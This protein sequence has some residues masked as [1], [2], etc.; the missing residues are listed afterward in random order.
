MH[1]AEL[2][3]AAAR[4]VN[5]LTGDA[6]TWLFVTL[7]QPLLWHLHLMD[8]DDLAYDNLLWVVAGALQVGLVYLVLRPLEWLAPLERWDNRR[9]IGPDVIYTL[10]N[11]LGLVPL[12]FFLTLQPLFDLVL[13]WMHLHGWDNLNL[14]A[15]WPTMQLHPLLGFVIYLVVLDFAGYWYHRLQHQIGWWWELHAVHHS[16]R[17]LS[18][19]ADDRNHFVDDALQ[20]AFFAALALFIGVPPGQFIGLALLGGALQSLQHANVRIGFGRIGERLLV[21][22]RFHRLHHA[23]GF[24]HELGHGNRSRLYGCNFGVL[25]PWWDQL[26]GSADFD[27]AP[28]ATGVREQMPPPEGRGESYGRGVWAQQWL[29]LRRMA[30]RIAAALPQRPPAVAAR[31]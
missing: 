27:T 29:G 15:L 25:L 18:L 26:F 13:A 7:V 21:S 6:Q 22:P 9:G 17:K 8:M 16:Q 11:R 14:D 12:L 5:T 19:W 24:G 28:L 20:A 3:D 4:L 23:V 31:G 1:P 2:F 10:I 30:R